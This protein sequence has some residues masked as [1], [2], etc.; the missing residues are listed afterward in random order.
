MKKQ[1]LLLFLILL[2]GVSF[3]I[4]QYSETLKTEII[5]AANTKPNP[6]HSWSEM[7][8][9]SDSIQVNGQIITNLSVPVNDSD[10]ATK[11][12]VDASGGGT[13]DSC[14]ILNSSTSG[15]SCATGYTMLSSVTN[16][17]TSWTTNGMPNGMGALVVGVGGGLMHYS[18]GS[19]Y[20]DM[21]L[22]E[23]CNGIG[24]GLCSGLANCQTDAS[25]FF[26][27]LWINGQRSVCNAF[28]CGYAGTCAVCCK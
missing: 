8:S 21:R 13:Y 5:N 18:T 25:Y 17:S 28:R 16:G 12:Y 26:P 20:Y 14:Y 22:S 3:S 7:E 4:Y 9:D 27:A 11:A 10:A 19:A 15:A 2:L 23:A 24:T 6:G 1:Y